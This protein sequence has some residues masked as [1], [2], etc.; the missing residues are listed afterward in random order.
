L[1]AALAKAQ[2]EI[3][4]PEKSLVATILAQGPRETDRTFRYASLSSGLDIVRKCL[5]RHEI[6]TVQTTRLDESAG[7][8]RLTTILAHS[9]G[10]WV[11]SEW[12]VCPIGETNSPKRMGAA[13]T[14]A[15]RY[16]L[17][18]LVG[19]AGEDDLD[20]PDLAQANSGP[21]PMAADGSLVPSSGAQRV[22]E[23]S[24]NRPLSRKAA[25]GP[26]TPILS[27]AESAA[28]RDQL[29]GEIALLS[30]KTDAT[31]WARRRLP[32]KNG[33]VTDDAKAIE[34]AFLAHVSR[35]ASLANGKIGPSMLGE[36]VP[37]ENASAGSK[38][39][40]H[41]AILFPKERRA[42]DKDHLRFVA[43]NPCLVCGSAPS[44]AHH[45]RFAQA[46]ALGRKVSDEFTVPLCRKH[47]SELHHRGNETA[48]WHD[49]GIEP[50]GVARK[51]WC[52]S[53]AGR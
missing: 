47:H 18:T 27:A 29:L 26:A 12:P 16:A 37:E 53:H 23:P 14:Y 11:S 19:I 6:A 21:S 10:E 35:L 50:L 38:A 4:N 39:G 48:W 13:L 17:F 1:A 52:E 51:L 32:A 36:G 34:E 5:G 9:S 30:A 24:T 8:V 20:A 46:R 42:R 7:L 44:D 28:L 40:N 2:A 43:S 33:L 25:R 3:V 41:D 31:D 15:R 45:I 22:P 49:I